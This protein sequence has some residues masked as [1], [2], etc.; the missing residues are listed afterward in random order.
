MP[1]GMESETLKHGGKKRRV[2]EAV[3]AAMDADEFVLNTVKV[4]P[5][6]PPEQHVE[7]LERDRG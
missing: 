2:F 4:E 6:P 1:D 3:T 5:Y 7:I